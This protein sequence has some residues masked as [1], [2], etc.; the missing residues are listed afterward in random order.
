VNWRAKVARGYWMASWKV[1]QAYHRFEVH[2]LSA[3]DRP[4][5]A[6]IAGYHGRPF[7]S[8]LLML[9][10][11]LLER[12]VN[13]RPI[14][15]DSLA[16]APGFR[17]IFEGMGFLQG[18]G[19][20]LEAAIAQGDKI[21]V[22]PG[23]ARECTRDSK[24]RYRVDWGGRSGYARMALRYRLPI[25]PAGGSGIDDQYVSLI[26]GYNVARDFRLPKKMTLFLGIGPLGLF[27]I[28]PPF[29]VKITLRLGEPIAPDGDP[30]SQADC[31]ALHQRVVA[32]VQELLDIGRDEHPLSIL[33]VGE[34]VSW[35]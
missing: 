34:E 15:H 18:E 29:P 20:A 30:D 31:D 4:G 14:V 13:C 10:V 33:K 22:T 19:P 25:I 23:G 6:L 21:I 9:Q 27:P 7:A 35:R 32:A 16:A 24:V 1:R 3:L 12:G 11:H 26:D 2:G 17:N 5:S 28:S 8:D